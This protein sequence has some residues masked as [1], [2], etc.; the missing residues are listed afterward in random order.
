MT[1]NKREYADRFGKTWVV[2][3]KR[4]Q[5][6]T[7]QVVFTCDG[8]QLI[9]EEENASG[10]DDLTSTRLKELYCDAERVLVHKDET[11][12]VGYRMRVGGRGGRMNA[13]MHTRFRSESGAVR[14]SKTMLHFSH[15]SDE[16]LQEQLVKAS[17]SGA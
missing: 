3:A 4:G 9:A 2:R 6:Q 17:P 7:G 10:L 1:S 5:G 15:M 16:D 12:Y 8:V 11:W 13:G 14:Y